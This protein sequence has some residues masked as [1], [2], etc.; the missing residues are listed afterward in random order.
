VH[1]ARVFANFE[2]FPKV[3]KED[4]YSKRRNW[5]TSNNNSRSSLSIKT[6]DHEILFR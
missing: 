4:S 6:M 2:I 3:D 1:D 5:L